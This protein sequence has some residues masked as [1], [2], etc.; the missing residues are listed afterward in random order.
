M[1]R[2]SATIVQEARVYLAD[3]A[4]ILVEELITQLVLKR[5]K[6]ISAF[7]VAYIDGKPLETEPTNFSCSDDVSDT[8]D[9]YLMANDVKMLFDGFLKESIRSKTTD[10]KALLREFLPIWERN[11]AG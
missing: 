2:S 7:I 4:R 10:P 3:G 8:A 5:P 11:K 1:A 9:D 6:H